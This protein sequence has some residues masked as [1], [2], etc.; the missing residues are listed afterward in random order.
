MNET[1]TISGDLFLKAMQR[2]MDGKSMFLCGDCKHFGS[3]SASGSGYC[4]VLDSAWCYCDNC[5][6]GKFEQKGDKQ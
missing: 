5:A 3:E 6:C 2:A 4:D 1:K